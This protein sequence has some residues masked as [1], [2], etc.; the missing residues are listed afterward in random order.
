MVSENA[1]LSGEC[2]TNPLQDFLGACGAVKDQIGQSLL[3]S[4]EKT[5]ENLRNLSA[6]WGNFKAADIPTQAVCILTASVGLVTS[7]AGVVMLD[8]AL[9]TGGA[10][11]L[12]GGLERLTR[13]GK[14]YIQEN[15]IPT[16]SVVHTE[17]PDG[18]EQPATSTQHYNHA[19]SH[20][21]RGD[22]PGMV[23]A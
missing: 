9:V 10:L 20:A 3:D 2:K 4:V 15:A 12:V 1:G 21:G 8:P 23:P 16:G 14:E 13:Y 19:L 22:A 5:S 11:T 7:A 17:A 18:P 6:A